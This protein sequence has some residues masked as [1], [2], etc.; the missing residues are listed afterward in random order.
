MNLTQ[1]RVAL[2]QGRRINVVLDVGANTG[3]FA[4]FLRSLGYRGRIVSFEPLD[5]AFA[6]LQR[7][8][9]GDANW[10]SHNLALG[11]VE[12]TATINISANSQ[13]S[14]FLPFTDRALR[15]DPSLGYTSTQQAKVR[16]L[17]SVVPELLRPDDVA[18]LKID[19]QGYEIKILDGASGVIDRFELI[20]VEASFVQVYENEILIA[21]MIKFMDTL[22]YRIVGTE[23]GWDD[24]K[25]GEMLQADLIFARK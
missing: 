16:R 22:G 10:S 8:S 1:R 11:D 12:T 21:D 13:A 17:D 14:S 20:Q 25:T 9:A 6:A 7:N 15:I 4:I 24:P 18:Y 2:M 19:A 3:Q 5:E 23:P